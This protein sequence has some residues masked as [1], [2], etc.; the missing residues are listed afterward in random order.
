MYI[1]KNLPD[2]VSYPTATIPCASFASIGKSLNLDIVFFR[3]YPCVTGSSS[4][5]STFVV[6]EISSLF[7]SLT[8]EVK[9]TSSTPVMEYAMPVVFCNEKP[10]FSF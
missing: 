7:C 4:A 5:F 6:V 3:K 2:G 10:S 9:V 1:D 8:D